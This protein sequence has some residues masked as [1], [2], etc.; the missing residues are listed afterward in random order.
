MTSIVC[1]VL[2]MTYA[3]LYENAV[4]YYYF[5]PVYKKLSGDALSEWCILIILFKY[6]TTMLIKSH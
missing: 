1:K 2:N 6:V 5:A 3:L 4:L